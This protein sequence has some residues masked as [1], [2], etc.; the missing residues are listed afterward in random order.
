MLRELTR[1]GGILCTD[2]RSDT[3]THIVVN[4]HSV[5]QMPAEVG[6]K[7]FVVK[8]EWFWASI[9]M[10]ACADEN[11]HKFQDYIEDFLSPKASGSVNTF[12]SPR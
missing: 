9:Q 1:N 3:C 11:M 2:Y 5:T 6:K 7:V 12:F 10:E 8:E 4:N